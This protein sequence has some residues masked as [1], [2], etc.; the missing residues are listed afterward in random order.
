MIENGYGLLSIFFHDEQS[1][2]R[3]A[4]TAN[5]RIESGADRIYYEKI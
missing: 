3:P 4:I 1:H 2:S 5:V